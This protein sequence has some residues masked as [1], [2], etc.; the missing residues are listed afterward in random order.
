MHGKRFPVYYRLSLARAKSTSRKYAMRTVTICWR[1]VLIGR[2]WVHGIRHS[3]FVRNLQFRP[4]IRRC[5]AR[6]W[7]HICS[8][9]TWP[10]S[11]RRRTIRLLCRAVDTVAIP[12]RCAWP[13]INATGMVWRWPTVFAVCRAVLW[14]KRQRL[15]YQSVRMPV[16]RCRR[17]RRVA[18]KFADVWSMVSSMNANNYRACHMIRVS[19]ATDTFFMVSWVEKCSFV[20]LKKI[21]FMIS[22]NIIDS[23]S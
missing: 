3:R 17:E 9:A 6:R 10:L 22:T 16:Y 15:W 1:N 12:V 20:F 7:N 5:R 14:A 8:R 13:T 18:S 23:L 19:W 11:G 4:T 21:D 2:E